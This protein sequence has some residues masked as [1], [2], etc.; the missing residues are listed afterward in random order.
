L[1]VLGWTRRS[2]SCPARICPTMG[3]RWTSMALVSPSQG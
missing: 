3:P 2:S 1:K